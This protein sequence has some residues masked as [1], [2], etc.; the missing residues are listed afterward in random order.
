MTKI[1]VVDDSAVDRRIVGGFLEKDPDLETDYAVHGVEALGKIGEQV[2]DLVLTDLMMPEMGGLELVAAVRAQYPLVPVILMTSKGSEE[3]AVQ[4]LQ[5]G[6]AS[7]VPKRILAR[8]LLGTVYSVL[9]AG[10]RQRGLTRL[11]ECMTRVESSFVLEND[12]SL[13]APLVAYLQ[14]GITQMGLCD[15]TECTRVG[16]ALEEAM[17]NALYHGNLEVGSELLEQEGDTYFELVAQR[18]EQAPHA[19][20]RIHVEAEFS[21][22]AATFVV[23][24]DGSGF[25]PGAL[26]DPT[27]PGNLEKASGRGVLLMKTFMDEVVYNDVG[28]EVTLL[29]RRNRNSRNRNSL[30]H[31]HGPV[32]NGDM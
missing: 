11:M 8:K 24:D 1:L 7:Y 12:S 15:E 30:N 23:R 9:A 5:A 26:P 13:F 10:S 25:D 27:D 21:R 31:N 18:R 32:Q 28:N 3:T 29:K 22:E 17:A 2:P 4:A 20:R 14:E 6:A 19:G 16:V